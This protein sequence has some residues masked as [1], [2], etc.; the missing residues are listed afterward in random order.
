MGI[1]LKRPIFAYKRGKIKQTK[2]FIVKEFPLTLFV[3]DYELITTV[4]SPENLRE[5]GIG[6]LWSEGFIQSYFDIS[7]MEFQEEGLLNVKI[8]NDIAINFNSF[9]RRSIA[10]CCGK[11]RASLYFINDARQLKPI[12]SSALF[13]LSDCH[14]QIATLEEKSDTFFLS[15]GVHSAALADLNSLLFRHEDIGRHNAVDKVL[16]SIIL[17]QIDTKDKSLVLTGRISSEIIIKAARAKIPIV[18]SKAAPTE[19]A[20]ELAEELN[21]TIIGFIRGE[22]SN[23]Y[24]HHEKIIL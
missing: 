11:G 4:C 21:I 22:K 10:S 16:G 12:E 19:L 23:I 7:S 17:N 15:G 9:L 13:K 2:D 14:E 6:F 20:I 24:S 1:Y 8:K 5:L 18:C 3:N